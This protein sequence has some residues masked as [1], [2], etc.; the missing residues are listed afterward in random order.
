MLC[1]STESD[2]LSVS[3]TCPRLRSRVLTSSLVDQFL[4]CLIEAKGSLTKADVEELAA[5]CCFGKGSDERTSFIAFVQTRMQELSLMKKNAKHRKQ[6][7]SRFWG[8]GRGCWGGGWVVTHR[9]VEPALPSD[10]SP[11]PPSVDHVNA[12]HT[13]Q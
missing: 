8:N 7:K 5:R 12:L 11:P 10:M 13:H 2:P 1:L 6:N 4:Q 9:H 3:L